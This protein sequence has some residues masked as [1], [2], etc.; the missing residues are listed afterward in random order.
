M[1]NQC[2]FCKRS[3]TFYENTKA[4]KKTFKL[5]NCIACGFKRKIKKDDRSRKTNSKE[6][7]IS[8]GSITSLFE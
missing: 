2:D 4:E 7:G 1:N 3:D 8:G 6:A 5:W